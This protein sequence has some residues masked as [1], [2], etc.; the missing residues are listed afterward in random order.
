MAKKIVSALG[1]FSNSTSSGNDDSYKQTNIAE[2]TVEKKKEGKYLL[3]RILYLVGFAVVLLGM[4]IL[5]Y[6]VLEWFGIL[7]GLALSGIGGWIL[8]FFTHRYLEIEYSYAIENAEFIC[9]EI[10]GNKS[11]KL[12]LRTKISN[13]ERT[14]PYEGAYKEEI[15]KLTFSEKISLLSTP[16][17]DQAY[18]AVYKKEDGSKGLV[19]FEGCDK[20]LKAFKYYNS[21]NTVVKKMKR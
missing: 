7:A 6:L 17:T 4:I 19:L 16:T 20:T 3:A 2:Y 21:Q 11:D 15:D 12:L 13:V 10:Y 14:V 1:K 5:L 8:W 9:T 18:C